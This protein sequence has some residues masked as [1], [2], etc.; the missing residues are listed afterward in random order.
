MPF[1]DL[2]NDRACRGFV[3]L[4]VDQASIHHNIRD[5]QQLFWAEHPT[6]SQLSRQSIPATAKFFMKQLTK[7]VST[8]TR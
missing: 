3:R 7:F 8:A 4:A 1:G 6:P 2:G 5:T